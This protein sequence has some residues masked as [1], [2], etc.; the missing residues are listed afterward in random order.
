MRVDNRQARG[1]R[2]DLRNS[3]R[4]GL[5]YGGKGKD[6]CG[7]EKP[8]DFIAGQAAGKTNATRDAEIGGHL[9]QVGKQRT[10]AN[11]GAMAVDGLPR[12]DQNIV[13]L[14]ATEAAK[15]H[16]VTRLLMPGSVRAGVAAC[17][18]RPPIVEIH[19]I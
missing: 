8:L 1:H 4:L 12:A 7:M 19:S 17:V 11:N 13:P 5:G 3:E 9:L 6:L 2:F 15:R 16:D 14:V 10:L 18:E